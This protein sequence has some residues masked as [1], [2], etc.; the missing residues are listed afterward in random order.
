MSPSSTGAHAKSIWPTAF[1]YANAT[2]QCKN[3]Q[4]RFLLY[5]SFL[6]IFSAEYS[7]RVAVRWQ[8]ER[9]LCDARARSQREGAR[10]H[11]RQD[12]RSECFSSKNTLGKC[13]ACVI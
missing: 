6:C 11:R 8:A 1:P 3:S 12:N 9:L 2:I 10:H 7:V 4:R 13:T 5:S